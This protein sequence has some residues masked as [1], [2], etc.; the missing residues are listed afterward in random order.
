MTFMEKWDIFNTRLVRPDKGCLRGEL[1]EE[2][3]EKVLSLYVK[4]S[5]SP[6][7]DGRCYIGAVPGQHGNG[8]PKNLLLD[9]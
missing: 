9:Q 5:L 2:E 6:G 8:T 7:P 3:L 1:T 4:G